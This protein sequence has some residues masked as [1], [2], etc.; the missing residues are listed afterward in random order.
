MSSGNVSLEG[1]EHQ[2]GFYMQ[3]KFAGELGR[4]GSQ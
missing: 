1:Q 3:F 4:E 2:E